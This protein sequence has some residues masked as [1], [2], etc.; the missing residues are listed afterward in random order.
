MRLCGVNVGWPV[1]VVLVLF[2][3]AVPLAAAAEQKTFKMK[4][5]SVVVG[6]VIDEGEAAYLVRTTN[7]ETIRVPYGE[8]EQ[9]LKSTTG[10]GA[11]VG[12]F[13]SS[14]WVEVEGTFRFPKEA[15]VLVLPFKDN[16]SDDDRDSKETGRAAQRAFLEALQAKGTI[17]AL[18]TETDGNAALRGLSRSEALERLQEADADYAVYGDCFE[19]YRVAPMTYRSDRAGVTVEIIA[20]DGAVVFRRSVQA[21]ANSNFEEPEVVLGRIA[22]RIVRK[23]RP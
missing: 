11:V 3:V 13:D 19:F 10:P 8:I 6:E 2:A 7:E 20:A 12:G 23:I 1:A 16:V 14:P 9:V 5:G 17:S 4:D 21:I 22:R 15:A 18:G